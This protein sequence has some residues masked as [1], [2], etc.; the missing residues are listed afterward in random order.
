MQKY[1]LLR[2][3]AIAFLMNLDRELLD[4]IFARKSIVSNLILFRPLGERNLT[5]DDRGTA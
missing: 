3:F 1:I 2:N 5:V 4:K